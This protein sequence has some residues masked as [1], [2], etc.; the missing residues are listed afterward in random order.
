MVPV[1]THP[2]ARGI[3]AI[4]LLLFLTAGAA[5]LVPRLAV[6]TRPAA[7]AETDAAV[8]AAARDALIGYAV[9]YPERVNAAYGPG[10]L[11]CPARDHRGIAGPACARSTGTTV[12]RFPWHTLRVNDLRDRSGAGL[13]YVL[14][15]S[16]RYNPKREP[17][18]ALTLPSLRH[19]GEAIVAAVIA[20]GAPLAYQRRRGDVPGEWIEMRLEGT[21]HPVLTR[22]LPSNDRV[23]TIDAAALRS[24]LEQRV[25]GTLAVAL[26]DYARAHGGRLPWL[27]PLDAPLGSAPRV[28]VRGGRLAVHPA[29]L[30][31]A[32]AT[33]RYESSLA[34]SWHLDDAQVLSRGDAALLA[35]AC[36]ARLPCAGMPG[37]PLVASAECA[38]WAVPGSLR[39]PAD[40]ARCTA[41]A[42]HRHAGGEIEYRVRFAVVADD[43]A[44][45]AGP[46]ATRLRTR[47]LHVTRL[48]AHARAPD[49]EI[50]I[51]VTVHDT[52]GATGHARV[53]LTPRTRG[54]FVVAGL[55]YALDAGAGELP[56]WLVR[57]EWVDQ[58]ALAHAACDAAEP[59]LALV[60]ADADGQRHERRDI[61]A[62]LVSTGPPL[63]S[64]AAAHAGAFEAV[65]RDA[66]RDPRQAFLDAPPGADFNDRVHV[67]GVRP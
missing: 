59:C 67:F 58:V 56:A 18:N 48:A 38:W 16:H 60:A 26:N 47:T 13:W 33:S 5:L 40:H 12:G 66:L 30:P 49:L 51:D 62:L 36:L 64:R 20:P 17:L 54:K 57:N 14:A 19:A 44:I 23:Q 61:T 22:S 46:S 3:A 45:V 25:L 10:Y 24:A 15:E 27:V 39:P 11:P 31:A 6:T 53:T 41:T 9:A 52:A 35:R 29:L 63:A 28:G 32:P 50:V 65:T 21:G 1:N 8:L 55:R 4:V 34:L 7:Y 42:R 2:R 43:A 37:G